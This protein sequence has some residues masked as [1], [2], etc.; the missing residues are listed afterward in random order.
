MCIRS[1]KL[2]IL[3]PRMLFFPTRHGGE[4]GERELH[5]RV[6]MFD[7]GEWGSLIQEYRRTHTAF[8][9]KDITE[10]KR[11]EKAMQLIKDAELS[12][13]SR[14]LQS[15]ELAPGNDATY[16]E[17]TNETFEYNSFH[18]TPLQYNTI[19]YNTIQ[20]NIIPCFSSSNM[21]PREHSW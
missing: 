11:V 9:R 4:A 18:S 14:M 7:S 1:W 8:R 6:A 13:A 17:L 20:Y 19:Q 15:M 21:V 12:H 10:E 2:F 16:A 3:L 5:R